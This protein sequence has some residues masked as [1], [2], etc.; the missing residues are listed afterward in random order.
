MLGTPHDASLT[1]ISYWA[2]VPQPVLVAIAPV[3][4]VVAMVVGFEAMKNR[5][6]KDFETLTLYF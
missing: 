3:V 5:K 4:V 2:E 1:G 6:R